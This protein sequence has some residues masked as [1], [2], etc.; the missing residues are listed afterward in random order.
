MTSVTVKHPVDAELVA[1]LHALDD[2]TRAA[3]GHEALPEAVWRA[4]ADR[5]ADCVV[6]ITRDGA[7]AAASIPSDSFTPQYRQLAL[8]AT[9][10][11]PDDGP[12]TALRAVLA[13]DGATQLTAWLPGSDPDLA[14][15]LVH[16]GFAETRRQHRMEVPLP[17]DPPGPPPAG[18]ALRSFRTG[19]D[20]AA[21]LRVNNRA[22]ANHPEQ[23]GWV[24]A[25]LARRMDEPWFDADGFLLAW[26][27]DALVGSCWTKVHTGGIGEIFVIGVDPDAQGIGLGRY[28]VLAGLDDLAR[29]RGCT[30]GSLYVAADNP[31]AIGLYESLGFRVTR[32]DTAFT[33]ARSAP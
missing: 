6:A 30:A 16:A 2:A 8:A 23:G 15:A 19:T 26:R 29:R 3:T 7:S 28:L 27:G 12:A 17:L 4:L 13:A 24:E 32:T 21:W 1:A 31:V 5:P 10:A 20:E 14:A 25:V 22:F 18:V 9:D 11:A 33:L